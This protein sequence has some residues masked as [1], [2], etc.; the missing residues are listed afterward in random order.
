VA[1]GG[2]LRAIMT[3]FSADILNN[4]DS[5]AVFPK[6]GDLLIRITGACR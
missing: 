4:P 2:R 6:E 1:A 3:C 5:L